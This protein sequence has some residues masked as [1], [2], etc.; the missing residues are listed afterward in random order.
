MRVTLD[1]RALVDARGWDAAELARRAGLDPATAESLY[2]G[3]STAIDLAAH[4]R[5]S[6]AL[7]V[8]PDE[9][10]ASVEEPHSGVPARD[11]DRPA[12][13]HPDDEATPRGQAGDPRA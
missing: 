12:S 8:R 11:I 6:A 1:I 7:G 13:Q 4:G 3:R 10:L 2:A 9:I 5:V